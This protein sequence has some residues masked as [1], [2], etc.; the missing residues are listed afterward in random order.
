MGQHLMM[1]SN[2]EKRYSELIKLLT[3]EERYKYLQLTQLIGDQ[4]FGSSRYLNQVFYSSPEWRNCRRQIILRD[5]GCDL[6]IKSK[7]ISYNIQVHHINP[8]TEEDI[9]QRRDCLFDPENLITVSAL[10]HKALTYG[11][12]IEM[13]LQAE[14]QERKPYDTCPW[15]KKD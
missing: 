2:Y 7:P 11:S 13:I 15:K 5:D 3:F 8:I 10:T 4:T 12:P 14:Y 1:N 9:L 6:G